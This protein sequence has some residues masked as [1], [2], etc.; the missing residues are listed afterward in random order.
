MGVF[1]SHFLVLNFCF[2]DQAIYKYPI[3]YYGILWS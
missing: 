3:L 2:N 1:I